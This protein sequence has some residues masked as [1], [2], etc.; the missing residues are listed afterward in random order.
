[1]RRRIGTIIIRLAYG[2]YISADDDPFLSLSKTAMDIFSRAGEPGVWLVDS[3]PMR[4]YRLFFSYLF[5]YSPK[6]SKT[7]ADMGPRDPLSRHG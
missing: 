4:Q 7:S 6:Y 2:H 5:S 3:I 1:M